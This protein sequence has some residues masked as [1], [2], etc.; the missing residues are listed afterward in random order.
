MT[1][2]TPTALAYTPFVDP[3]S[4]SGLF[5]THTWWWLLIIPMALGV[6]AAYKAVRVLD[7]KTYPKQVAFFTIQI[8][9]GIGA[10][11]LAA[12]LLLNYIIPFITPMPTP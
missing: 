6:A 1:P 4:A 5:D 2:I 3:I 12:V 11:G 9:L 10:L 8:L 7:M